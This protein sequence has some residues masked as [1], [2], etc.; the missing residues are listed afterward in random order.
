M[1]F[2]Q[3]KEKADRKAQQGKDDYYV[4]DGDDG[5][6]VV[7]GYVLENHYWFL[8]DSDILYYSPQQEG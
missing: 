7:S 5:L 2:E 6:E 3:L 1:T 8:G 4:V